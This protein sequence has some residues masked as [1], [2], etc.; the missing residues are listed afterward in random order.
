LFE[1][2]RAGLLA[3]AAGLV[4]AFTLA[5]AGCG[6]DHG[7]SSS[8]NDVS[9]RIVGTW[10]ESALSYSG[11]FVTCPNSITVNNVVV[12]SCT[13]GDT[14]AFHSDGTYTAT[15]PPPTFLQL[16]VEDCK[17]SVSGSKV[18]LTSLKEGYDANGDGVITDSETTTLAS[19]TDPANPPKNPQKRSQFQAEVSGSQLTLTPIVAAVR[20]QNGNLIVNSDGTVNQ[21]VPPTTR[22]FSLL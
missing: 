16:T 11:R 3:S 15:Y 10:V 13:N 4:C 6:G 12:D 22:F 20:D 1:I 18:T 17:Y 8:S 2:R 7:Y 5:L 14:I 9:T 21:D 19:V